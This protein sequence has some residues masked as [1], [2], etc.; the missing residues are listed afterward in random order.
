VRLRLLVAAVVGAAAVVG[1]MAVH[2]SSGASAAGGVVKVIPLGSHAGEFCRNDRAVLFED[3]TGIRV[4][5][6]PARTV[7]GGTDPRLGNVDVLLVS[8]AHGDHIGDQKAAGLDAGTCAAPQSVPTPNTN[9]AEIAVAKSSAVLV[10]G[11]MSAF[12]GREMQQL[13]PAGPTASCPAAGLR[14]ELVVPRTSPCVGTLRH[15]GKRTAVREAGGPGVQVAVVPAHHSN[16]ASPDFLSEPEQSD[17]RTN[18]LT[19]Y[20]GPENGYVV[21]FSNGLAVYM[22]GDTGVTADMQTVVGGLYGAKLAILNIGDI[23]SMGPE[24]AAF[25]VDRLVRPGSV[26]PSHA[27]EVAT[28]GGQ[29]QPGTRTERFVQLVD[30]ADVHLP[31]SERV[32]EFE[33]DGTCRAGCG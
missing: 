7:G 16:G 3:P 21:T 11:E 19:A 23:F 25:A 2:A 27:N 17:L 33:S 28:Q 32:M 8:S 13:R 14:N 31:L 18:A 6:D 12:L 1:G 10:G 30:R 15:G 26:I 5:Y 4:L 22:S 24:E 20:V 29:L 9:A